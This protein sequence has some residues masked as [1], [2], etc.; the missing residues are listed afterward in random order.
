MLSTAQ[1]AA[2]AGTT[3]YTVEREIRRGNLAAEKIGRTW[4]ID[5]AEAKRWAAQFEP[6]AGLHRRQPQA[7][8]EPPDEDPNRAAIRKLPPMR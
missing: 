4:V 1:A 6:Y 7:A 8:S 3:R 5:P 2:L